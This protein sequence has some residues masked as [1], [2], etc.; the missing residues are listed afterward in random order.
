MARGSTSPRLARYTCPTHRPV[1]LFYS[2]LTGN[3]PPPTD[4]PYLCPFALLHI[5]LHRLHRFRISS[6]CTSMHDI[7]HA[8][9]LTFIH[10][11]F[12]YLL[13]TYRHSDKHTMHPTTAQTILYPQAAVSQQFESVL[14]DME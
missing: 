3:Y 13:S 9:S 6:I 4:P 12:L 5:A 2:F 14:F 1:Q 7:F 10:P 8:L 11:Y